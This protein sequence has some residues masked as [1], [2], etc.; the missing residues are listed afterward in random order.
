MS[1]TSPFGGTSGERVDVTPGTPG[2]SFIF[3]GTGGNRAASS[4]I[5]GFIKPGGNGAVGSS[6]GLLP[7]I[8]FNNTGGTYN[9]S[10]P[11][12]LTAAEEKLISAN[13]WLSR[14]IGSFVQRY[15]LLVYGVIFVGF[16]F[17]FKKLKV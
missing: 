1:Q 10:V 9:T 5:E 2:N 6:N 13:P 7:S 4:F 8:L 16:W 11:V 14:R 15:P 12:N 3:S 17:L